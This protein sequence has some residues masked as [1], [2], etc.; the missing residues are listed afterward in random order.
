MGLISRLFGGGSSSD[1][2]FKNPKHLIEE[3][4]GGLIEKSGLE[5][6]FDIEK[7][8]EQEVETYKVNIYGN[9]EE[10]LINKDGMLLE[11]FQLFLKRVLQHNFAET[12]VNILC[13]SNNYR[14]E[15][16]KTLEG[17]IEKLKEKALA[18][19]R[20]VYVKALPPK[21]RRVVHQFLAKDERV[22]SKS[23][24]DGHFKKIKIY[25]VN[26]PQ[27]RPTE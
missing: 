4:L 8:K 11:A 17:M 22:K 12:P 25:A 7:D 14:S 13:D 3:V 26:A 6:S 1:G 18:Q 27:S 15:E 2:S 19:G 20:P 10:M 16:N 9:D 24:G 5:L 21:E 23:I